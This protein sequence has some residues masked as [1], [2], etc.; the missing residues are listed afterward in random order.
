MTGPPP[1]LSVTCA[2]LSHPRL[3]VAG[4]LRGRDG[5]WFLDV[6]QQMGSA[7][8]EDHGVP[9][10]FEPAAGRVLSQVVDTGVLLICPKCRHR[11]PL[12]WVT[13]ERLFQGLCVAGAS[14]ISLQGIAA[15][16]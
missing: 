12:K 8:A 15:T 9:L 16:L 13:V 2:D 14:T 4:L 6:E 1:R 7:P 11:R 10:R 5:T 3:E